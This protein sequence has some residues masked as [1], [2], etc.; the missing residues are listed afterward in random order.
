MQLRLPKIKALALDD[1]YFDDII[2]SADTIVYANKKI[3]TKPKNEN[4]A[5][6]MLEELSNTWHQVFTAICVKHQ[7]K[8]YKDIQETKILFLS[9][10]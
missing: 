2:L 6:Q 7:N 5:Y 9:F 8:I 3:Y 4:D 1:K 10:G